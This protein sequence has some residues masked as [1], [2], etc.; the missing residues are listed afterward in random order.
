MNMLRKV[1]LSVAFERANERIHDLSVALGARWGR[2]GPG[3]LTPQGP[4]EAREGTRIPSG[5][6]ITQ[7]CLLCVI[8]HCRHFS[9][10]PSIHPNPISGV[11]F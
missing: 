11:F 7:Q 2:Q 4:P 1:D 9:I 10:H 5:T 6:G 3:L 8:S